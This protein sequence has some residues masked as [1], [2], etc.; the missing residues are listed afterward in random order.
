MNVSDGRKNTFSDS[1]T[2]TLLEMA[3]TFSVRLIIT[4]RNR[5]EFLKS[6]TRQVLVQ[7]WVI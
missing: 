4:V 7:Y 5:K 6:E 3:R 1:A 2:D